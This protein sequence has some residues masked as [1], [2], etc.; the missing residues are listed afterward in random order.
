MSRQT[1]S[2]HWGYQETISTSNPSRLRSLSCLNWSTASSTSSISKRLLICRRFPFFCTRE[3]VI[4]LSASQKTSNSISRWK[5]IT[6]SS[7]TTLM[8]SSMSIS[9]PFTLRTKSFRRSY[10]SSTPRGPIRLQ[11]EARWDSCR[12]FS[13]ISSSMR[14]AMIASSWCQSSNVRSSKEPKWLTLSLKK[15]SSKGPMESSQRPPAILHHTWNHTKLASAFAKFQIHIKTW[16]TRRYQKW[17]NFTGC[18]TWN[19]SL[20]LSLPS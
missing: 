15:C 19:A 9:C 3:R 7:I 14:T 10:A 12:S 2:C 5:A 16:S 20:S 13:R 18:P 11:R 4:A 17:V 8:K 1:S 6:I